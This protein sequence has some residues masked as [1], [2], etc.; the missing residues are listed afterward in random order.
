MLSLFPALRTHN[1]GFPSS[2]LFCGSAFLKILY[3][4]PW[5]FINSGYKYI[6]GEKELTKVFYYKIWVQLILT[7]IVQHV[8]AFLPNSTRQLQAWHLSLR[9][10]D[11]CQ[12]LWKSHIMRQCLVPLRL[13]KG[14]DAQEHLCAHV[15]SRSS[16][17]HLAT[18]YTAVVCIIQ[19][20]HS[21]QA[22][23]DQ[24]GQWWSS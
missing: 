12:P 15:A 16:G 19:A 1:Q 17:L 20:S 8:L 3:N 10:T 6:Q 13:L 5:Q 4:H 22:S 24:V 14:K 18:S 9:V 7:I 11:M 21:F 23:R 2:V